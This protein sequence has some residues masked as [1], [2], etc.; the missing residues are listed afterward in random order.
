MAPRLTGQAARPWAISVLG[1][2]TRIGLQLWLHELG[3][4]LIRN[5]GRRVRGPGVVR[6]PRVLDLRAFAVAQEL[7]DRAGDLRAEADEPDDK[8]EKDALHLARLLQLDQISG[9]R[10]PDEAEEAA[11]DLVRARDDVRAS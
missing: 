7:R 10:V 11:R 2:L 6:R 5:V 4:R 1:S 9:M 3:A 8:T